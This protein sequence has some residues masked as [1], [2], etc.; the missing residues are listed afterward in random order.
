MLARGH[1]VLFDIDWQGTQQLRQ[2]PVLADLVSIF[3]LPPSMAELE[4]RL[5]ARGTDSDDVIAGRMASAEAAIRPWAA[6]DY[7]LNNRTVAPVLAYLPPTF[8]AEPLHGLTTPRL[9]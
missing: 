3:I 4:R 6:Y 1:D 5:R 9:V 7:V 8:A 2:K